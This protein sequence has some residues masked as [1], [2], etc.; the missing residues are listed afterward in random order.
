M[1]V[2][3]GAPTSRTDDTV[4]P[5]TRISVPLDASSGRVRRTS[6]DTEAMLG[7]A[8]PRNP[9]VVIAARS[10]AVE[11]L[12]VACRSSA[13]CASSGSIPTPSSSTR[14]SFL[15][16]SSHVITTRVAAASMA[17]STSSLTTEAGRSTTSPAAI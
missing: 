11:I 5:L 8:S 9:W 15:P 13:S 4:P 6:R 17:F 14:T 7:S 12:L 2:P 16:P 1:L 10:S 3:I